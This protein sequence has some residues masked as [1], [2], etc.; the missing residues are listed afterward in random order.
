MTWNYRIVKINEEEYR[1]TEVYYDHE[2]GKPWGYGE[3]ALYAEEA[4]NVPEL[5]R[6]IAAAFSKPILYPEADFQDIEE[7]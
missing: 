2:T 5:G 4:A 1:L 6:M 7:A 3:P